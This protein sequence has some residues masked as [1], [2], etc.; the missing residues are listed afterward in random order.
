MVLRIC[1]AFQA[2]LAIGAAVDNC[3]QTREYSLALNLEKFRNRHDGMEQLRKALRKT[4]EDVDW[5]EHKAGRR[6]IMVVAQFLDDE[7][8]SFAQHG[9]QIRFR[10]RLTGRNVGRVDLTV[11][12]DST[13]RR[14]V[15][16]FPDTPRKHWRRAWHC[17]TELNVH[18]EGPNVWQQDGKL[19]GRKPRSAFVQAYPC[20]QAFALVANL[21]T[22]FPDVVNYVGLGGL[23]NA[24][25]P[26]GVVKTEY[27]WVHY[28]KYRLGGV[29]VRFVTTLQYATREDM[30]VYRV[31]PMSGDLEWKLKEDN[32]RSWAQRQHSQQLLEVLAKSVISNA[33]RADAMAALT[34]GPIGSA[35]V[36]RNAL[37]GLVLGVSCVFGLAVAWAAAVLL[38]SSSASDGCNDYLCIEE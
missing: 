24:S 27:R 17:K 20:S 25:T 5:F 34:A 1:C 32:A 36:T 15:M 2:A 11:K 26:L 10:R 38:H 33:S 22:A 9:V 3:W 30:Q 31:A 6:T 7:R 8:G 21:S 16:G 14:K 35:T 12:T 28:D 4:S 18:S 23:P 29:N 19:N 37:I 13:S